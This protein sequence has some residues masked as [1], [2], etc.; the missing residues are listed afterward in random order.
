MRRAAAV[1][2]SA[3]GGADRHGV[4]VRSGS[5]A[6]L[7][8]ATAHACTVRYRPTQRSALLLFSTYDGPVP[9]AN[10]PVRCMSRK[11]V[12]RLALGVSCPVPRRVN[13]PWWI[14]LTPIMQKLSIGAGTREEG[15]NGHGTVR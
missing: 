1:C 10:C 6:I 9:A 7:T 14:G 4:G 5:T 2:L 8:P 13:F 15:S 3:K 11:P 12:A